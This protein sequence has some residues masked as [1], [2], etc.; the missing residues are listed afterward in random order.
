[1]MIISQEPQAMNLLKT[2]CPI[3]N[4][5][6]SRTG[7]VCN[8]VIHPT[9]NLSAKGFKEEPDICLGNLHS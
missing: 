9:T 5:P 6:Q 7:N 2:K 1:M 3:R 4:G 8:F